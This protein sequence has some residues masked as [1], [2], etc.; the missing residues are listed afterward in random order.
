[1]SDGSPDRTAG[2][3]DTNQSW[4]V[5]PVGNVA[6]FGATIGSYGRNSSASS[7]DCNDLNNL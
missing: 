7:V 5:I 2:V 1:M 6:S 4:G 3:P